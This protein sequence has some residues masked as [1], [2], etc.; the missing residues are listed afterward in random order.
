[1]KKQFTLLFSVLV[2]TAFSQTEVLKVAD[3]MP[4]FPGCE[5]LYDSVADRKKCAD[6]RLLQVIYRNIQYPLAARDSNIQGT[7]VVTFVVEKD[8]T[9]S[10]AK[11][12][13]NIG[14][15]CGEEALRIINSMNEAGVRWIPGKNKGQPVAVSLN[16]PV[17]FKLEEPK[18][19]VLIGRDSVW[20]KTD[21]APEFKGGD[22][23]L[24]QFLKDKLDYPAAWQDS[25]K[26]GHID[27][28]LLVRPD[29]E[30]YVLDVLN[31]SDLSFEFLWEAVLTAHSMTH[32]WEPATHEGRKVGAV[33][34]L[35]VSF[36]PSPAKCSAKISNFEKAEK[37]AEEGSTLFNAGKQEEGLVKMTEAVNLAPGNAQFL[38]VRGQA[39]VQLQKFAEACADYR[40]VRLLLNIPEVDQLTP[41]ICSK[42]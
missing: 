35:R 18:D 27:I 29:G 40:R 2:F 36:Y 1:M 31:Y 14:G 16:L 34:E 17:K 7:V 37:L 26:I 21:K 4:R 19:Y 30:T 25:C 22:A 33:A 9:V 6:E 12:A 24:K 42:K 15:G 11:I 20:T 3:E 38:Y 23:D 8:G 5:E 10:N 28:T 41:I 32:L 39:Y 13:K